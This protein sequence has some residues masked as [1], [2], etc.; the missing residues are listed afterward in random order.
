[1]VIMSGLG[2][3]GGVHRLWTHRSYKANVPLRIFFATLYYSA[4]QVRFFLL[5]NY[6]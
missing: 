6:L 3:T 5:I 1:M 4:G 2:V